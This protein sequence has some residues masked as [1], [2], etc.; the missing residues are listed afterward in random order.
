LKK[1]K[2]NQNS[3]SNFYNDYLKELALERNALDY[4]INNAQYDGKE[5]SKEKL[6]RQN[7][8][9]ARIERLMPIYNSYCGF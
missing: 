2:Q 5:V 1:F 9:Q 6:D 4:E 7:E 8:L 3:I